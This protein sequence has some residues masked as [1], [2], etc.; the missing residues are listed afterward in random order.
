MIAAV[1]RGGMLRTMGTAKDLPVLIDA[2]PH[3][4]AAAMGA[5]GSQSVNRTFEGIERAA[6]VRHGDGERL[7]VVVAADITFGHDAPGVGRVR[8]YPAAHGHVG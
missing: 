2:M 3:H 8:E 1:G 5:N 7:V 4:A 6:G